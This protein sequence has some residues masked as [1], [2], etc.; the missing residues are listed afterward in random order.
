MVPSTPSA[1]TLLPKSRSSLGRSCCPGW[2]HRRK[3]RAET[4]HSAT[5]RLLL[6]TP[7]LPD[8]KV[9]H[10]LVAQTS[11]QPGILTVWNDV[12]ALGALKAQFRCMPVAAELV[13]R[14]YAELR[15]SYAQVSAGVEGGRGSEG[16]MCCGK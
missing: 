5:A 13:G 14:S 7:Q 3:T 15:R 1:C 9:L 12:L 6:S 2:W 4:P 8:E 11:T 16:G 10:R